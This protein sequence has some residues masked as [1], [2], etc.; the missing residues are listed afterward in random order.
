MLTNNTSVLFTTS[1]SHRRLRAR[2]KP[3]QHFHDENP[4]VGIGQIRVLVVNAF[5]RLRFYGLYG[6]MNPLLCVG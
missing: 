3:F 5:V 1:V 6:K 2:E 4:H